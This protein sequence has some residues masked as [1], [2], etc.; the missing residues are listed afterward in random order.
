[1]IDV[2]MWSVNIQNKVEKWMSK[3]PQEQLTEVLALLTALEKRGN[4]L[5]MP[6][7]K[8]LGEKLFELRDL[9][10]GNRIYYTFQKEKIIIAFYS[11]D[12][13]S[14]KKDIKQARKLIK[15]Y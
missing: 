3:L 15:R 6:Y 12:K 7:S 9:E 1:M 2:F 11:G 5:G 10:Y 4:A 14:Q 13:S 8:A